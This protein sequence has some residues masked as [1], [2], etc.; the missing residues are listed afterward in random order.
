MPPTG[1]SANRPA[2]P[3]RHGALPIVGKY[4][5][6]PS[7][8]N[9]GLQGGSQR[10]LVCLSKWR[11]CCYR[12]HCHSAA[13]STTAQLPH[14]P[15]LCSSAGSLQDVQGGVAPL[16][17]W[18]PMLRAAVK[19]AAM[20]YCPARVPALA[21]DTMPRAIPA[22]FNT[23]SKNRCRGDWVHITPGHSCPAL[24]ASQSAWP[25]QT[26]RGQ[27]KG[28]GG[29]GGSKQ[30]QELRGRASGQQNNTVAAG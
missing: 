6:V 24:L 28:G 16:H 29:A 15:Q 1:H 27:R 3:H 25:P 9:C 18:P 10:Q 21:A 20:V 26:C 30:H 19:C 12:C 14:P 5:H 8:E 4:L 11:H 17:S 22:Q 2:C 23:S 7:G 13:A